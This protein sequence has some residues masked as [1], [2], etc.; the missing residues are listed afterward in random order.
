MEIEK[1]T[2]KYQLVPHGTESTDLLFFDDTKE[3]FINLL[4]NHIN[5]N[6]LIICTDT[7]I[8]KLPEIDSFLIT[9]KEKNIP[10]VIIQSGEKYKT[11]DSVLTIIE[12]ALKNSFTRNCTFIAIGGGVISD[13][14]ALASSLF[15]RG[16]KLEIIPTTLL[17]MVDASIGGKTACDYNNYKNMIGTFYPAS[18]IY[19]S[20]QI[21][22]SLSEN[23][24]F[25]GLAEAIKTAML[26]S[27]DLFTRL[28]NFSK[29]ICSRDLTQLSL[30][31]NTCS[32]AKAKIVEQDLAEKDIRKQLNLGHT[33]A[34]ALET[35]AGF[36]NISHGKAVAWGLSRAIELSY[37]LKLCSEK[38]RNEVFSL[39]KLY[40]YEIDQAHSL[41]VKI[42]NY[43]EKIICAMKQDK[44]NIDDK[45]LFVLQKDIGNTVFVTVKE[46]EILSII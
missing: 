37:Q 19:F 44:K 20:S 13:I 8:Q 35:V 17:S 32:L 9:C 21:V 43:K 3:L 2:L 12:T 14:T 40:G 4:S 24:Y 28:L 31:I 11:F 27:K 7:N 42:P 39:L 38:Y 18:K 6:Q 16:A 46:S 25:S 45:I 41:L 33:F 36:E 15:K 5:D 10:I 1:H 29:Q 30:I 23:D 22:L 34:H 26:Y